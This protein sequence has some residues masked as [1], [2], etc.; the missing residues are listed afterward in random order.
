MM[1]IEARPTVYNGIQMRSRLEAT[2]AQWLDRTG[3]QWQYEPKCYADSNRQ[4]L[5]DFSFHLAGVQHFIEIKPTPW[6]DPDNRERL[7]QLM[8]RMQVVAASEPDC[9]LG[10]FDPSACY[11]DEQ[12][13]PSGYT[14]TFLDGQNLLRGGVWTPCIRRSLAL[15]NGDH[16]QPRHARPAMWSGHPGSG[17]DYQ[18][19]IVSTHTQREFLLPPAGWLE[20]VGA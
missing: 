3:M 10:I 15:P 18:G 1:T 12:R 4:Y 6:F 11:A 17:P 20:E 2:Y 5:P 13:N 8:L 14:C 19:V 7:A 16:D 9:L